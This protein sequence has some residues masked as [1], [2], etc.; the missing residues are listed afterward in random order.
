MWLRDRITY[1]TPTL[2]RAGYLRIDARLARTGVQEYHG[3]EVG[4]PESART[5]RVYR[6]PDEVFTDEALQ[7][8]A[9]AP[10][11]DGHPGAG[12]TA[13]NWRRE[14]VGFVA[15]APHRAADHVA[16]TLL[17]TDAGA[18]NRVQ[19]AGGVELSCGYECA[20]VWTPGTTPEGEAYDCYQ[21]NIRGNHVALV[22]AG[23]CGAT[24]AVGRDAGAA[25]GARVVMLRASAASQRALRTWCVAAGFSLTASY[26]GRTVSAEDFDF[27]VT[28]LATRSAIT[29]PTGEHE[30]KPL[31]VRGSGL[32]AFGADSDI[33]ALVLPATDALARL[34]AHFIDTY[35]ATPTYDEFRPHVS[36]SYAWDGDPALANVAVPPFDI[37]FDRLAID[38]MLPASPTRTDQR[39]TVPAPPAAISDCGG[40]AACACSRTPRKTGETDAMSTKKI[41]INGTEFEVP[42][43]AADALTAERDAA[44]TKTANDAAAGRADAQLAARDAEIERLKKLVPTDEQLA[45]RVAAH[46]DAV[47]RTKTLAPDLKTDGLSVAA[48]Q[49]GAVAAYL[50][51]RA[52]VLDG[53]SDEYVSAMFDTLTL[54]ASDGTDP[55]VRAL[56]GVKPVTD[57]G[58]AARDAYLARLTGKSV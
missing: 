23:R 54:T 10:V 27:H 37:T 15:G 47:T 8:F 12:V 24:C 56:S 55:I 40:D 42:T 33:P 19:R 28:L 16:A 5:Y 38:D 49:R 18:T 32:A 7:S 1:D 52:T 2:T 22:D 35:G 50:G 57:A 20:L 39:P 6:S 58:T 46:V 34:R 17:I 29:L 41:T 43:A 25:G 4:G 51:D 3:W 21:T 9:F 31:T 36:L 53:R 26:G 30:I 44:G 48:I 11:T 45:A 13:E 14:A